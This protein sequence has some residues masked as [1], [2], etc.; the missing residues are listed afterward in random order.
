[1]KAMQGDVQISC[2]IG[3]FI[4]DIFMWINIEYKGE[5]WKSSSYLEGL[6]HMT[7]VFIV[8]WFNHHA[9][10]DLLY[11]IILYHSIVNIS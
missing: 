7:Y 3:L 5:C 2:G 8:I 1:M 10:I 4:R 6:E 9:T 11:Y